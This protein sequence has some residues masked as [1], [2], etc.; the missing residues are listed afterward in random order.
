MA[1]LIDSSIF[2]ALERRGVPPD[3]GLG[4]IKVD[5]AAIASITAS[6]LLAGVHRAGVPEHRLRREA[7][8]EAI[9]DFVPIL[10]F[11]LLT[12]RTYAR[13]WSYLATAGQ[14]IGA[15]DLLIASTALTCGCSV[16]TLNLRDFQRVPGLIVRQPDW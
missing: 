13:V 16:L 2:I 5:N 15:H 1:V 12:A 11:D 4:F 10:S 9:L 14:P 7:Y 6:E 3:D 8:V